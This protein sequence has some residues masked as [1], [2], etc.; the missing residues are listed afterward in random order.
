[1][2]AAFG[3]E[4]LDLPVTDWLT[5]RVISLPIHTEMDDEQLHH[6]TSAIF[7]FLTK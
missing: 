3:S 5:E 4:G 1:M 6:I 2:F 7:H